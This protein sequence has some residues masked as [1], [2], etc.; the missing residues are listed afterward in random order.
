MEKKYVLEKG[1]QIGQLFTDF[2]TERRTREKRVRLKGYVFLG[3]FAEKGLGLEIAAYRTEPSHTWQDKEIWRIRSG[4]KNMGYL[5]KE[6]RESN[7]RR[8]HYFKGKL[9]IG[10]LMIRINVY[11][12][13]KDSEGRDR[14][15]I[16]LT[17][18]IECGIV[19]LA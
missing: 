4:R 17:Q 19:R 15:R 9:D 11:P 3:I 5:V 10:G 8:Y 6:E 1:T 2:Y 14:Y 7:G 13:G 18:G 12:D 16:E